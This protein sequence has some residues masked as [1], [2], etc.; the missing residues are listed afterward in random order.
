MIL[1]QTSPAT[2]VPIAPAV[3]VFP[4]SCCHFCVEYD[5]VPAEAERELSEDGNGE[6]SVSPARSVASSTETADV[7]GV[8]YDFAKPTA[9]GDVV[10]GMRVFF[11]E[12]SP[13]HSPLPCTPAKQFVLSTSGAVIPME[14]HNAARVASDEDA[15]PLAG[16]LPHVPAGQP[17]VSPV[18]AR[19]ST[20]KAKPALV[21]S[22]AVSVAAA[23]AALIDPLPVK[24]VH[25]LP[26]GQSAGVRL[27][28]FFECFLPAL[29]HCL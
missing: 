22:P 13:D 19:D 6:Q 25:V 10:Q 11:K 14:T 26:V 24:G 23:P 29:L 20:I 4:I 27:G 21:P 7:D 1:H 2:L 3:L 16:T 8:I 17:G 5:R 15:Y 12:T 9:R 18:E 28:P